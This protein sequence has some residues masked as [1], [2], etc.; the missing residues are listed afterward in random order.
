MTKRYEVRVFPN[1]K[2]TKV[3]FI[4]NEIKTR[5]NSP[6]IKGQ[7]NKNLIQLLA[8]FFKQRKKILRF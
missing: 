3:L 8:I 4:N 6:A 7:A 1:A 2:F 5:I